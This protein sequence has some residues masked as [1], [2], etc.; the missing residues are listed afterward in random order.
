M[1]LSNSDACVRIFPF[2]GICPLQWSF[3]YL[4]HA[5]SKSLAPSLVL[6]YS[7][8]LLLSLN[9]SEA[10][11]PKTGSPM[12]LRDTSVQVLYMIGPA[13]LDVGCDSNFSEV[14]WKKLKKFSIWRALNASP[15]TEWPA[16]SKCPG[17]TPHGLQSCSEVNTIGDQF[18]WVFVSNQKLIRDISNINHSKMLCYIS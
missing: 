9:I 5:P 2:F 1:E 17:C 12:F 15:N 16:L 6:H 10:P 7:P 3:T 4:P 13:V 18:P 8:S 14:E 11:S